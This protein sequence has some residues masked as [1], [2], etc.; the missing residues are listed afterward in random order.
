VTQATIRLAGPGDARAI[1]E[2][3]VQSW[4]TTYKGLIPDT[5]LAA[6][7]VEDSVA[8]W[9]K[10]LSAAPNTTNTFVAEIDGR[11]T[12]FASGMMKPEAKHGFDAELTGIYLLHQRA[13]IGRRLLATVAAAQR[14]H[15]AT[16]MIAWV[17][18]GNKAARAFFEA[19][20]AELVVEQPFNWDGIDLVEAGYGWHDLS[21][22]VA[23]G[24]AAA[25]VH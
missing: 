16:G 9:E 11:V 2:V 15:G 3:R 7:T 21:A 18:A 20:G 23:A 8:L 19:L 14:A 22:L 10:V 12:G 6:M 17:I 1:A 13:G 25:F 24:G 4:R 5:Y